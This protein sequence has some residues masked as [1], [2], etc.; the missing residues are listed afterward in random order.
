MH[1]K[2]VAKIHTFFVFRVDP[3]IVRILEDHLEFRASMRVTRGWY[4]VD[5]EG[6]KKGVVGDV[7]FPHFFL[8]KMYII[9][10]FDILGLQQEG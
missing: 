5:A 9:I 6:V 10:V 4:Y 3:G 1:L 2:I 8:K 7:S